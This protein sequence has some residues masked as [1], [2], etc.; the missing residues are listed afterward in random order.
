MGREALEQGQSPLTR[1]RP[2]SSTGRATICGSIPAHAGE[3]W[4]GIG[5]ALSAGVNPRSRG[6]GSKA[7]PRARRTAGQSPLTRGRHY[8]DQLVLLDKGSIPA[9]AGEA[10]RDQLLAL[11]PGVNPR[12]RGGGGDNTLAD[13]VAQGQSPLTRG[14]RPGRRRGAGRPG[15][16]PAHAGEAVV[17]GRAAL[18]QRVNPRSRGGGATAATAC[19]GCCGQS[20]LTRGRLASLTP[21][22]VADRSIPAHAGEAGGGTGSASRRWVNPRSRGGGPC[23]FQGADAPGGQ[24]PLTRGRHASAELRAD[25]ER[26]IPA[27]AGE[28]AH[29]GFYGEAHGVN[30]RSR[31]GGVTRVPKMIAVPGQSPL[32][33]GRLYSITDC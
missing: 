13:R 26:S 30:P 24:S 11:E 22:G 2:Q 5:Q 9:H 29:G 25:R 15:S 20:P 33:R 6:G 4:P 21:S 1:G 31:G 32:T 10:Q 27:H 8:T 28:A 18:H 3:A 17:A 7:R 16:I 19:T 14:R 12:S 23:P